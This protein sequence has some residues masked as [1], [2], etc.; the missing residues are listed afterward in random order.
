MLKTLHRSIGVLK[1]NPFSAR[2]FRIDVIAERQW[3]KKTNDFAASVS[4]FLLEMAVAT[5]SCLFRGLRVLHRLPQHENET[6][7]S[8]PGRGL[9]VQYG[10]CDVLTTVYSNRMFMSH[11]THEFY[12]L[13]EM[14]SVLYH[15]GPCSVSTVQ[16]ICTDSVQY[17][18]TSVF[19]TTE[20]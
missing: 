9:L 16:S 2:R 12:V 6:A 18:Y 7:F 4:G 15:T 17:L 14:H 5:S 10:F 13:Q 3:K 20:V 11:T 19:C 8:L 1:L